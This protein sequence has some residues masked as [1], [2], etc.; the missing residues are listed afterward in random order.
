MGVNYQRSMVALFDTFNF[1]M[2]KLKKIEFQAFL[3]GPPE[4]AALLG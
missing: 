3:I 2:G 4:L 1:F